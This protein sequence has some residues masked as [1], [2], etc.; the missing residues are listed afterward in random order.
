MVRHTHAERE[1][2]SKARGPGPLNHLLDCSSW[3]DSEEGQLRRINLEDGTPF[4]RQVTDFTPWCPSTKPDTVVSGSKTA[5]SD[6]AR[7][8]LNWLV[9]T[10]PDVLLTDEITQA[11]LLEETAASVDLRPGVRKPPTATARLLSVG[12]IL[13]ARNEKAT[14]AHRAVALASGESGQLLR[15]VS[16]DHRECSWESVDVRLRLSRANLQLTGEWGY[17]AVPITLIRFA[18]VRKR[19]RPI[20]WLIVQKATSTTVFEPEIKAIPIRAGGAIETSGSSQITPN[21]LLL[22]GSHQTGGADHADASF[23]ACSNGAT[24]LAIID[25]SGGWT[26]WDLR[27][28]RSARPKAIK[29]VM[30]MRG[31]LTGSGLPLIVD[32]GARRITW[33]TVD[34]VVRKKDSDDDSVASGSDSEQ[35]PQPR[36][37]LISAGESVCL[38]DTKTKKLHSLAAVL[39]PTPRRRTRHPTRVVD[40]KLSPLHPS[41][42]FVLTNR[43]LFW[44]ATRELDAGRLSL[45]TLGSRSHSKANGYQ[46]LRL[47]VS[48]ATYVN[49]RKA[50]FVCVRLANETQVMVT[51]CIQPGPNTPHVMHPTAV[52]LQAPAAV[53]SIEMLPVLRVVGPDAGGTLL[54]RQDLKFFEVLA[55]GENFEV[56]SALCAWVN[57]AHSQVPAPDVEAPDKPKKRMRAARRTFLRAMEG[58]FVVPDGYVDQQKAKEVDTEHEEQPERAFEF[59]SGR[60]VQGRERQQDGAEAMDVD[61]KDVV[62]R[63]RA[64]GQ[65]QSMLNVVSRDRSTDELLQIAAEWEQ[66][67]LEER[68]GLAAAPIWTRQS[69]LSLVEFI[70]DLQGG[71]EGSPFQ[72]DIR[73]VAAEVCLSETGIIERSDQDD[74]AE[75]EAAMQDTFPFRS[76]PPL[77]PSQELPGLPKP[78][79]EDPVSARLRKYTTM[80]RVMTAAETKPAAINM[81]WEDDADPEVVD[82]EAAADEEEQEWELMRR[83]RMERRR[84][85]AEKLASLASQ[86]LA[87]DVYSAPVVGLSSSQPRGMS[88]PVVSQSQVSQPRISQRGVSQPLSSQVPAA[89]QPRGIPASQTVVSG[90]GFGSIGSS[91][92]MPFPMSQIVPGAHGGRQ[93]KKVKK[94]GFR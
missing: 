60:V 51:W 81:H 54:A 88:Q 44:V 93:V 37:L 42:A 90:N 45:K 48:P 72:E 14:R 12:E 25:C 3:V 30:I 43:R 9:K 39:L 41:Q 22:I 19:T 76:S 62:Q 57:D 86:G 13:D 87:S 40:I 67:E 10:H 24:R 80:D 58:A 18:V 83:R 78:V 79:E 33:L 27:G 29:P 50:C 85:R 82:F 94:S 2:A 75:L 4:F 35:V 68:E 38:F 31:N 71:D 69:G 64:V 16:L 66:M 89:S 55:F 8:Q 6:L 5:P 15:I 47:D 52:G 36:A 84:K 7:T 46:T 21:P 63:L 61:V 49:G 34:P 59:W 77:Q 92:G 70:E 32:L 73:R 65:R 53:T 28:R 20:R 11:L 26:V 74:T 91:Q 1:A 56:S 23:V 17:D